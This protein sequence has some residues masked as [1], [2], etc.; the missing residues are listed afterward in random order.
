LSRK[1][2]GKNKRNDWVAFVVSHPGDKDKYVARIG[3]PLLW[4]G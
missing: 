1:D 4:F 3:H 2:K